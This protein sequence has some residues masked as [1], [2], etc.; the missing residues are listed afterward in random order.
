MKILGAALVL[1]CVAAVAFLAG[2]EHHYRV[3]CKAAMPK[4]VYV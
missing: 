1:A 3:W 2:T 4:N